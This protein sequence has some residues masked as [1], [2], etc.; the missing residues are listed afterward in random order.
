MTSTG[1]KIARSIRYHLRVDSGV[2]VSEATARNVAGQI[3]LWIDQQIED[4][5][6]EA[7]A[8]LPMTEDRD[9]G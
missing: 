2:I 9:D 1:E 4:R 5:V 6:A 8:G 3:A 7:L